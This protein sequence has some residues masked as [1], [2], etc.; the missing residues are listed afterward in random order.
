MFTTI[1][2]FACPL[3]LEQHTNRALW[4]RNS[5]AGRPLEIA[6]G[7]GSV[8]ALAAQFVGYD[9]MSEDAAAIAVTEADTSWIFDVLKANGI[10]RVT[11]LCDA[12]LPTAAGAG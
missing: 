12:R 2:R 6:F 5:V 9:L 10:N 7:D 1:R 4:G 3:A 8:E 11:V